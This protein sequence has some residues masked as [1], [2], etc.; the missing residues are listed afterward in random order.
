[1]MEFRSYKSAAAFAPPHPAAFRLVNS[2]RPLAGPYDTYWIARAV[3]IEDQS[4]DEGFL[5]Y[6]D[7]T[8]YLFL[9]DV[10]ART[11][12]L[13]IGAQQPGARRVQARRKRAYVAI[14]SYVRRLRAQAFV[15]TGWLRRA[16]SVPVLLLALPALARLALVLL[17]FFLC[18]GLCALLFAPP[19]AEALLVLPVALAGWCFGWRGC[20]WTAGG[21]MLVTGAGAW[22]LPGHAAGSLPW[23]TSFVPGWSSCMLVGL[24]IAA[25]RQITDHLLAQC[26]QLEQEQLTGRLPHPWRGTPQ[27]LLALDLEQS[28]QAPVFQG[29]LDE[30]GKTGALFAR[31]DAEES[32]RR[33]SANAPFARPLSSLP[34]CDAGGQRHVE[35]L[36]S[37]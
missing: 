35:A 15:R 25:L 29:N 32:S 5:I 13:L 17:M 33:L 4:G 6:A 30:P 34:A 12:S 20:L 24:F 1:M 3:W 14:S 37:D 7:Q 23:L 21:M 28:G 8:H 19:A 22:L 31:G 9:D 27:P 18:L 16:V 2:A 11:A 10:E 26:V 36:A